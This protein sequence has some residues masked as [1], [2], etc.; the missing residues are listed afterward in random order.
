[1]IARVTFG[2]E[3]DID[4][5]EEHDELILS[6]HQIQIM[7][8]ERHE[9]S[10]DDGIVE[11]C[12]EWMM[13]GLCRSVKDK[14]Y[15]LSNCSRTCGVCLHLDDYRGYGD[16]DSDDGDDD[17]NDEDDYT[18]E[19]NSEANNMNRSTRIPMPIPIPTGFHYNLGVA[20]LVPEELLQET[21]EELLKMV[22]Y[23]EHTVLNTHNELYHTVRLSC[24]NKDDHCAIWGAEGRCEPAPTATAR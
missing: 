24:D 21:V 16:S 1:M 20:Q 18:Y 13:Q 12:H 15:M 9:E 5:N 6:W 10:N 19:D 2:R 11:G 17:D 22:D 23:M 14:E 3:F 4:I 8:G 7:N